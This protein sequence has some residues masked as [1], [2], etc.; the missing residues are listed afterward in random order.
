MVIADRG[1]MRDIVADWDNRLIFIAVR[2]QSRRIVGGLADFFPKGTS[3][4]SFSRKFD[5][6]FDSLKKC[7]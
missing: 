4:I 3:C 2:G 7:M 1:K 6:H 5:R